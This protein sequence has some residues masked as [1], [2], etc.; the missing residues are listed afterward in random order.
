MA[1]SL[2]GTASAN[3]TNG[4]NLTVTLPVG[5]AQNDV[6]YGGYG[7]AA[8]PNADI[9][10]VTSGYTELADLFSDDSRDCNFGVFRK[11][12]GA[13]PDSTLVFAGPGS[14]STGA[15]AVAMVLRGVDTMTPEDATP[16][17][18]TGINSA[19]PNPPSITTVTANAWVLAFGGSSRFDTTV[20][21]PTSYTNFE[22]DTADSISDFLA[23]V[24]S[25]EITAPGAE[26]PGDFQNVSTSTSD[27]WCAATVAVRPAAT[28]APKSYGF[29]FG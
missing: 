25:R 16:T 4:A 17:T 23:M 28:A 12:Q 2:V 13:S 15:A 20:D 9:S 24:A 10:T 11:V 1:I 22:T 29:I 6:V 5:V 21:A 3:S 8:T 26:D 27:A 18:A 19:V 14:S 7:E